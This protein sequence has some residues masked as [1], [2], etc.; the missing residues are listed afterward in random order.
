MNQL[1]HPIVVALFIIFCATT[2]NNGPHSEASLYSFVILFSLIMNGSLFAFYSVKKATFISYAQILLA[3]LMCLLIAWLFNNYLHQTYTSEG[4]AVIT[5]AHLSSSRGGGRYAV[6]SFQYK[7]RIYSHFTKFPNFTTFSREVN[8]LSF[9]TNDC[10]V[11]KIIE[12]TYT[13]DIEKF[14]S[15]QGQ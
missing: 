2:L 6:Y 12:K 13:I 8:Y 15:C 14:E 9:K 11:V 7:N 10:V 4:R 5:S 1:Y 3:S